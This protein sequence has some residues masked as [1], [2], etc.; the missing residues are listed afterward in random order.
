[1]KRGLMQRT[2]EVKIFLPCYG[3]R[4]IVIVGLN[5]VAMAALV[6][7]MK[8]EKFKNDEKTTSDN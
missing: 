2:R 1:M 6:A 3:M 4:S 7:F 5:R 8:R